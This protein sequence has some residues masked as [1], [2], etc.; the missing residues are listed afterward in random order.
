MLIKKIFIIKNDGV[1]LFGYSLEKA[2][3]DPALVSGL[4]TAMM[5]FAQET[6]QE[7]VS[8][9]FLEESLYVFGRKEN[10]VCAMQVS[11]ELQPDYAHFIMR[12]LLT[13]F[14]DTFGDKIELFASKTSFFAGFEEKCKELFD[15]LGLSIIEKLSAFEDPS[16]LA[17]SLHSTD[18]RLLFLS[19][20]TDDY[21]SEAFDIYAVLA[22]NTNKI[23]KHLLKSQKLSILLITDKGN[24]IHI[25]SL[26]LVTIVIHY[27]N[28]VFP[29]STTRKIRLL[30]P[31]LLTN[32]FQ[33][34]FTNANIEFFLRGMRPAD[35]SKET[36]KSYILL[37]DYYKGA[38]EGIAALF[39]DRVRVMSLVYPSKTIIFCK[40]S[41]RTMIITQ[42]GDLDTTQIIQNVQQL[43]VP[44]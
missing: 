15:S 28:E 37:N 20:K 34:L 35:S 18:N 13:S 8:Q 24:I 41:V 2:Q 44:T 7:K 32:R 3:Q 9:I 22:K 14:I 16:L 43:L 4:L 19:V 39:D 42:S 23:K 33:S 26:P 10:I 6:L 21:L 29:D 27:F 25:L 17:F 40:L 5:Q 12:T 31:K 38:Q 36:P 30:S 11:S 1:L